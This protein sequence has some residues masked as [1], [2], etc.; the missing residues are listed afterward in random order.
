MTA[1]IFLDIFLIKFWKIFQVLYESRLFQLLQLM[2][3]I[4]GNCLSATLSLKAVPTFSI[5]LKSRQ[6][7][8]YPIRVIL[9]TQKRMLQSLNVGM[10]FH[11]AK[12]LYSRALV[13]AL[14]ASS[15]LH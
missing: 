11:L 15:S 2:Q 5:K 4:F 12:T 8:S 1:F 7:L 9:L 6:L 3:E 10:G 13:C 14:V